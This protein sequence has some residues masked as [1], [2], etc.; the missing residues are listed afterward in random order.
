LAAYLDD[1][2]GILNEVEQTSLQAVTRE[3]S[4]SKGVTDGSAVATIDIKQVDD[5]TW[6]GTFSAS[7]IGQPGPQGRHKGLMTIQLDVVSP[8]NQDDTQ[9]IEIS[10]KQTGSNCSYYYYR[11]ITST[12][13]KSE[14]AVDI[15]TPNPQ[16]V[17]QNLSGGRSAILYIGLRPGDNPGPGIPFGQP[18][19]FCTAELKILMVPFASPAPT[20]GGPR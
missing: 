1:G 11:V 10:L 17:S 7:T 9:S 12:E 20:G 6:V 4:F 8:P 19:Y 14:M 18:D 5:I 2:T 15:K 13:T 16:D 3:N